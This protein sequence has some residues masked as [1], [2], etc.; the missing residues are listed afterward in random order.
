MRSL[1]L[2]SVICVVGCGKQL[3]PE[4][5]A[6]HPDDERCESA[7][8]ASHDGTGRFDV[9][10][11]SMG[12]E[13]M[14][15]STSNV[16]IL[17]TTMIDTATGTITP[18]LSGALVIAS[19]A[20]EDGPPVMV[21]Q[22]SSFMIDA[23]VRIVGD[24]PLI[25][26][27]TN[28]ITVTGTLDASADLLTAGAGGGQQTQG[29]GAG[30]MG[31]PGNN[32]ADAG[33]G[34]GGYGTPG[35]KGGDVDQ[36]AG[37]LAGVA[38]GD[39]TKLLGGSGGGRGAGPGTCL[40]SGGAGGGALQITAGGTLTL[41][42][43]INVGGGGGVGGPACTGDGGAAGGGGSGGMIY[44]QARAFAGT[45][46]LGANGGGGGGAA[47]PMGSI[48]GLPGENATLTAG[49]AGGPG[50]AGGGGGGAGADTTTNGIDG[51][52]NT[53]TDQNGGGGGGA[54]GRI[55]YQGPQPSYPAS[56]AATSA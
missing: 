6:A 9:A 13:G 5:C 55:Y 20:Q 22:A 15:T 33:G 35:G 49:G 18:G 30:G 12:V 48:A 7:G 41:G 19:I 56:P 51:T 36:R 42:G 4:F 53:T 3:N 8:D 16:A 28:D 27:A 14:L 21:I 25:F 40:S 37:G 2:V 10:H 17:P 46:M 31:M 38:Y 45:G 32:L 47:S 1:P 26:V 34:G 24:K 44:L 50:S 11:L 52:G 54:A 39:A 23:N 29:M 43:A